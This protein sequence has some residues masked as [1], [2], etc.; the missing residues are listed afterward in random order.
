[1]NIEDLPEFETDRRICLVSK[2][3]CVYRR[4][5]GYFVG[6]PVA[7]ITDSI[8]RTFSFTFVSLKLSI[9]TNKCCSLDVNFLCFGLKT[10]RSGKSE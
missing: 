3:P 5:N 6:A 4:G 1:M 7:D 10:A 2:I 9:I 8:L